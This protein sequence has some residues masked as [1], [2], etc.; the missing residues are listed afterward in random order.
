MARR[1]TYKWTITIEADADL[2]A[3][4]FNVANQVTGQDMGGELSTLGR[5]VDHWRPD[6]CKVRIVRAP[7]RAAL[8]REQGY[9]AEQVAR[10][11]GGAS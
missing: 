3:D 7:K 4:G 2:V 5:I 11:T 8:L 9:S 6:Q 10:M 1:R